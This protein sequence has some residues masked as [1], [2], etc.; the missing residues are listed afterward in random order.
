MSHDRPE[1]RFQAI[2]GEAR[3]QRPEGGSA[4]RVATGAMRDESWINVEHERARTPKQGWKLHVSATVCSAES[5]LRRALAVLLTEDAS[6]KLA[7][8][9]GQLAM[10][11]EGTGWLSQ[12]GKF[13]TVYPNDDAQAVRLAVALDAA[14]HGLRGPAIPSD[15]PL[16]S[17]SLVHYRYGSFSGEQIQTATGEIVP[18]VH[19][20]AGEPEADRRGT[21]YHQ[22]AWTVDPFVAAGVVPELSEPSP[23][24][25]GRYLLVSTL[26]QSAR[27]TVH[28]AADVEGQRRCVVKRAARDGQVDLDGRD[29]RDRLRYEAEVL[30]MLAPDAS[31]PAV[32]DLVEQDG[33]LYLLLEDVEGET[34][35]RYVS[36]LLASAQRPSGKQV[37]AWGLELSAILERLHQ[38][39][40]VH[41]DLKAT[42]VIVAPNGR[43]RLIDFELAYELAVP[44]PANG[45]G[46]RGHMSPGALAG[47]PPTVSDDIYGLGALLYFAATGAQ[48][49]LAPRAS[50][51]LDRPISLLNPAIG[52]ALEQLIGR[53]LAPEPADRFDSMAALAGE[54]AMLGASAEVMVSPPPFGAESIG[55]TESH[56]RH[57]ARRLGDS[58]VATA[59]PA[60]DDG[61]RFWISAQ[62]GSGP[63]PSRDLNAGSAGAVLAL[64]ELVAEFDDPA[65][66]ET[67]IE[68]ARWLDA[69]R[70]AERPLPGLY[71]GE[72]GVAA[73]LLRAGQVLGDRQLIESAAER[74]RW[75]AALPYGSPDLYNGT[76]GRL[77]LH[78]LL[79]DETADPAHLNDAWQA[80]EMLHAAAETVE[81]GGTRWTI[82]P[83]Y[84][85]M[86][87]QA[88][89]GYAHG[90][91][92]IADTL[93]DLFEATADQ[94]YLEA[95]AGAGRWLAR[96]ALPALS[97]GSGLDWPADEDGEPG[98][99]VWCHGATGV[100]RFFLHAAEL[101]ALPEAAGLA[102][103]A[104]RMVAHGTRHLGPTPCHGLAGGV[105]LLLDIY[106]A[107][108][109]RAYLEEARALARLLE[110]FSLERDGL[111]VW[112]SDS[113]F[114]ISP[115]YLVGYAGVAVCLL[116][117]GDPD[118]K[119]HQL[120][121][122]G[123]R[124]RLSA[125]TIAANT[126]Q[127]A[128]A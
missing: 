69:S 43:L 121:R 126:K 70:P 51:L 7:A 36:E 28:L 26:N 41:R 49:S 109:T 29:A 78:L 111:L 99:G 54:L 95:A 53:C 74:G 58:L 39:G 72:A 50:R 115:D 24:I 96:L 100:G 40:F 47:A 9:P 57:L 63:L 116:R 120:S 18:V 108:G 82:P 12:V 21:S 71:V 110:A 8:S 93:L 25:G 85:G 20:P 44:R 6:F 118:R 77:R 66:R 55:A 5:V 2:I 97:D 3:G 11:N 91:A 22:P 33:D 31:L 107:T 106:Q 112:R 65:Q 68:A 102:A 56:Y 123:F 90:A 27:G 17:G 16:A 87:G 38:R 64:A 75:I 92:G 67:L 122:R 34:L 15:R 73:A 76:A 30:T 60:R 104:A 42:N 124:G 127:E 45:R 83:G 89:L 46:T 14:T 103:S 59:Q 81:A 86:S 94:R 128:A 13:I 48:P 1:N 4:W 114:V 19:T 37:V 101:G 61:G 62:D 80:G 98:G 113:P 84:E 88:P 119:P 52:P 23:L 125:G 105:E 10:L 35:D 79:W 32:I 117:L